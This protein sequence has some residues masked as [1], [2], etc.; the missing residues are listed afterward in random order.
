[1]K[2]ILK[3][4]LVIVIIYA[5][6]IGVDYYRYTKY[7]KPIFAF[8]PLTYMDGGTTEYLGLGYKIIYFNR[9][10]DA[11][12]SQEFK[13]M[14]PIWIDYDE[15][16]EKVTDEI[17]RM[18]TSYGTFD[19]AYEVETYNVLTKVYSKELINE[20]IVARKDDSFDSRNKEKELEYCE[21]IMKAYENEKFSEEEK[22]KLYKY[23]K[24]YYDTSVYNKDL[25]KETQ[26]KLD[27]FLFG[28][29][30]TQIDY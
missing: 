6:I 13:Y 24:N 3:I 15:A 10:L 22:E 2:K 23:I 28:R 7:K 19:S 21:F 8:F 27:P 11:H 17:Y 4:L 18:L 1:M 26:S 25:D 14:G 5:I 16:Y 9:I 12:L 20:M 30:Y 29:D